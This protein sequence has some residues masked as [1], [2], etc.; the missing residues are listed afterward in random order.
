MIKVRTKVD[1][2]GCSAC[3]QA[4]PHGAISM[5]RD[6]RGFAYPTVDAVKCVDCGQCEVVCPMWSSVFERKPVHVY[7]VKH[8]DLEVRLSS[9]SGGAFSLFA[10]D[11][12]SRGGV[13]YGAAFDAQWDVRH[14]RITRNDE[15]AK[16]RGS[17]YVQSSLDG[18]FPQVKE[19]LKN[20]MPVLFSG[21]PCQIAALNR[22]VGRKTDGL[23]TVELI[24]GGICSPKIW[25]DYLAEECR[26][27]GITKENIKDINFRKKTKGWIEYAFALTYTDGNGV[28]RE[29]ET[30]SYWRD[31][32]NVYMRL[33]L[34]GHIVRPA[35]FNCRFKCGKSGAD[36]AIADFWGIGKF[37]PEF[38]EDNGVSL[39]LQYGNKPMDAVLRD[40]YFIESDLKK[41]YAGNRAILK[42]AFCVDRG[43]LFDFLHNRLGLSCRHACALAEGGFV[44]PDLVAKFRAKAKARVKRLVRKMRG[45]A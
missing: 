24:C 6:R 4:C 7:A 43:W 10:N 18:I 17:K 45:T 3:L 36:Y 41:A 34:H 33:F 13:V 19:D 2:C 16:L 32:K 25:S 42:S 14:I 37:H 23:T 28:L 1:C 11:M 44:V 31:I 30:S 40:S 38:F 26:R 27:L 22:F 9:A 12:L 5:P 20:G 21:L 39:L 8:R 35:C 15:L 29:M